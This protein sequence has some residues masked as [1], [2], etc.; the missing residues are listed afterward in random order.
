MQ[1]YLGMIFAFGGNF[2]ISGFQMCSGQT[3]GISQN[4]ALFSILGT[5]YG[6]NGVST[7]QLPDLRG[8]VSMHQGTGLG[9]PTY[10]VGEVGGNDNT[11]ILYNNMPI[12]NHSL[13]ANNGDGTTGIP[14]NTVILSKGP[15]TGSGPSATVGKIYTT[16]A[17]NTTLSPNAIGTAGG[18]IPISIMQPYLTVTYLIAMVGIFPSRN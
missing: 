2:A 3:L 4:A 7:F 12:H 16:V 8:R 1:P 18:S 13:N 10:V 17:T 14:S 9:L 5:F 6:G 11:S 15:V